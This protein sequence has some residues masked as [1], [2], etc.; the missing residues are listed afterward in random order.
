M[1]DHYKTVETNT[2]PCFIITNDFGHDGK[3]TGTVLLGTYW[4]QG[5]D[6]E[7]PPKLDMNMDNVTYMGQEGIKR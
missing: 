6:D 5:E 3:P 2:E 7:V 1:S 4:Y